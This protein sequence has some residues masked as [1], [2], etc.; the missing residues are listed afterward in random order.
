MDTASSSVTLSGGTRGTGVPAAGKDWAWLRNA[1][2]CWQLSMMRGFF[3]GAL[4]ASSRLSD[5]LFWASTLTSISSLAGGCFSAGSGVSAGLF[6]LAAASAVLGLFGLLGA[7][8]EV[9]RV[10]LTCTSEDAAGF[11][12]SSTLRPAAL[13]A[14][15]GA[16]SPW[17]RSLGGRGWALDFTGETEASAGLAGFICTA[18]LLSSPPFFSTGASWA[19]CALDSAGDVISSLSGA[20]GASERLG[21]SAA[22]FSGTGSVGLV[23]AVSLL[24]SSGLSPELSIKTAFLFCKTFLQ[25]AFYPYENGEGVLYTPHPK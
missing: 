2:W 23:F 16:G 22:A 6:T 20:R 5:F 4:R 14:F 8:A 1:W 18:S 15:S 24:D 3:S 17:A 25:R 12:S 9:L 21:C 19:G 13:W 10:A 7:R 11:R